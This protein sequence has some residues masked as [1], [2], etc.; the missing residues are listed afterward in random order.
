MLRR[1]LERRF[2][3]PPEKLGRLAHF[4]ALAVTLL[5]ADVLALTLAEALFLSNA[6]SEQLPY[7]Y[8]LVAGFSVPVA[9]VFSQLVDRIPRHRLFRWLLALAGGAALG[10]WGLVRLEL[11]AGYYAVY[12]GF[13]LVEM[14]VDIQFWVLVSDYFTSLELKRFAVFLVM[15][16]ALGGL[17]GGG[18]ANLLSN[19][20]PP[21]ALILVIPGLYVVALGQ[22]AWLERRQRP[23][24]DPEPED[25]AESGLLESLRSFPPLLRRYPIILLLAMN[26]L[27]VVVIR[28]VAEYQV[29]SIY[30]EA[31]PDEQELTGFL[32]LLGAALSVA[33]FAL[34]FFVTRPLI[35]RLGVS[36]MNLI[37][38][39]T[40]LA[41]FAGL[42]ASFRL[43]AAVGANVNYE[44]LA[45]A[46]ASPVETLNYNAVPRR[47]LGRVRVI[48]EG[49]FLPGG[50]ALAGV[51]LLLAGRYLSSEQITMVGLGL[52]AAL[53][54]VGWRVGRG[55]LSSLVELLRSRSVN[56]DEV[57][58]GLARLPEKYAEDVRALLR[59][60]DRTAQVLGVELAARMD[61]AAFLPELEALLPAADV[62]VRRALVK[63]YAAFRPAALGG[64]MRAL[65][66]SESETQRELALEALVAAREP[67]DEATLTRLLGDSSA[68][69]RGL[70]AVSALLV[71]GPASREAP[72]ALADAAREVAASALPDAAHLAMIQAARSIAAADP[73]RAADPAAVHLL[74]LLLERAGPTVKDDALEALAERARTARERGGA[75][76]DAAGELAEVAISYLA[77]DEAPVRAGAVNL[78]AALPQ[79]GTLERLAAMLE[80]ASQTVRENAARAL[81]EAGDAALDVVAPLL[82]SPRAEVA[83]A[84]VTAAGGVRSR[85]AEEMLFAHLEPGYRQVR[86]NL[87]WLPR[88][89]RRP[90]WLPLRTALEDSN[91]RVT[92]RVLHVLAALG[93]AR[94]LN[95]VR[96]ILRSNDPRVR[97]DAVETLASLRHR[98]FVEPILP[99]LEASGE[100]GGDAPLPPEQIVAGALESADRWVVI[101]ALAAV[102]A[103]SLPIPLDRLRQHPDPL[104]RSSV[105]H[106]L[107]ARTARAAGEVPEG[108]TLWQGSRYMNRVLFL[109]N[110]PLFGELSLDDLLILDAALV[111]KDYLAGETIFSEGQLGAELCILSRGAVAIRKRIGGAERELARLEPGECFGEMA[112]FDDSP[113]SATAIAANDATLLTL[114]RSR[115]LTLVAQ[116]PE[117]AVEICRVLSLR[118]REANE[119]LGRATADAGLT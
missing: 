64:K 35:Q 107:L 60:D 72:P 7:F 92:R 55:Y 31:F 2:G 33:E 47:F 18:A 56:L 9:G 83:E 94:T 11:L 115:F 58:E 109:K 49:L 19:Y 24:E 90:E 87:E 86:Q 17:A 59:S 101:G 15:A 5:T 22:A 4:L 40:T 77:H 29:F 44:T 80:D 85:R 118:L 100:G 8:L 119:R 102:A 14:L 34:I 57:S 110:I 76:G 54:A 93:H 75:P 73:D 103:G 32:G 116:R 62:S 67:L 63:L 88:L 104:V 50:T 12:I 20:F 114:E 13:T 68:V 61:P 105:L 82:A 113:R 45:N 99:L 48:S 3:L 66:A 84:A 46:V 106:T 117:I 97:A 43:P 51:L 23:L 79:T 108:D 89:E 112:L 39:I 71:R 70:A 30:E 16:M 27:L 6:G 53:V 1:I 21:A 52:S 42:A 36:R 28:C 37:Y 65:L 69:V 95:C 26:A 98:R 38:P 111:Q 81:A 25:E 10:L 74:R 78:L 91:Q 96:R 41:S